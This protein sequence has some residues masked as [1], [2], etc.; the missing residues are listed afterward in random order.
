MEVT[1][2][3]VPEL[4]PPDPERS[5]GQ[6]RHE[7]RA[8]ELAVTAT[9]NGEPEAVGFPCI[10]QHQPFDLCRKADDDI[11]ADTLETLYRIDHVI[12][13]IGRHN[14]VF[15]W[16]ESDEEWYRS[17]LTEADL[18]RIGRLNRD[19]NYVWPR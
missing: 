6:R 4:V 1:F 8:I 18:I 12:Y 16:S 10:E 9:G 7:H 2:V 13:K 17:E 5:G 3:A 11:D 15:G 14:M 19:P